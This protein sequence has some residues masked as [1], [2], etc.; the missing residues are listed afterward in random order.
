MLAITLFLIYFCM[1]SLLIY[2]PTSTGT[3]K[4]SENFDSFYEAVKEAFTI[5]EDETE[6]KE[7][8][9]PPT[10]TPSHP[11][12]SHFTIQQLRK[13]ICTR[14]LQEKIK[15]RFGKPVNR[16]RKEELLSVLFA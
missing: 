7:A 6:K 13:L 10:T 16:C 1:A 2:E 11:Q 9:C 5:G 15:E 8:I 4:T 12:P 14:Q 3:E